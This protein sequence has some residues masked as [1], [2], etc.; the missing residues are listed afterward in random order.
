MK[1]VEKFFK[2]LIKNVDSY[3][4][5][6]GKTYNEIADEI[7]MSRKSFANLRVDWKNN[8]GYPRKETLEKLKK[9]F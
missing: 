9:I 7:G 6:T 5:K 1:E 2:T 3:K 4:K 8:R